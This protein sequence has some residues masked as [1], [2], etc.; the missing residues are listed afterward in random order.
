MIE[1][2]TKINGAINSVVW[3]P[4]M[5]ALL[6][7]TGIYLSIRVGFIQI[8]KL[9][10]ILRC[11]LGGIRDPEAHKKDEF[12]IS[13][14]QAVMTA[15]ASTVGT[16]NITG[17]ATA[18]ALG[19]PGA[20]FWMWVSALFG[21]VTKFSEVVLAVHFREKNAIGENVGGPMYYIEKGLGPKFRWLSV[22]FAV[23]AMFASFGIGNMTQANAIAVA[24]SSTIGIDPKITG[25][26]IIVIAT[27]V[28]LG[29]IKSIARVT[30]TLVPIMGIAYVGFGIA[31][32][33]AYAGQIP[34]AFA[35]IFQGA[36]NP[37]SIGGGVAGYTIANAVR[38]GFARGIFSNEAGLGSAPIAHAAANTDSPV[39][40]GFWGAFEVF[41]DTFIICTFTALVVVCSGLYDSGLM[42]ADLTIT[43]FGNAIGGI[44]TFGVTMGTVL[45]ALSTILGWS[46]Y[47][48]KG[49]EYLFRNTGITK[50]VSF[51][52]RVV[53]V[54]LTYVGSI[55]SLTLVWDIADTLNGLMA[56]PNLIG[57]LG[58][59]GIAIR[60]TREY[61]SAAKRQ[62]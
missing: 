43:A 48:E 3:G 21:M 24:L 11:T 27:V 44:G 5:L 18:I 6:V 40:Q 34:H 61:F 8:T 10:E 26:V 41:F 9:G 15:L 37:S 35:V 16:G 54:L 7:G 22:L 38:Y 14:F 12:G 49:I 19:G 20:V 45:F 17:V 33:V 55:G 4:V 29:G 25:A 59:S 36:L 28:L 42:G 53:F 51:G 2:I 13:P 57:L 56:I 50:Q 60:L 30:S 46:Y 39:K 32:L 58:L 52:Y 47:G 62:K 31:A 1:T 23:F